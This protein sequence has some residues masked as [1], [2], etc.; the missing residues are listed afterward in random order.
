MVYHIDANID[1]NGNIHTDVQKV[2]PDG[3]KVGN[4]TIV[5]WTCNLPNAGIY[6]DYVYIDVEEGCIW[7]KIRLRIW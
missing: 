7:K 6:R 1:E 2:Y 3:N 5:E 4:N